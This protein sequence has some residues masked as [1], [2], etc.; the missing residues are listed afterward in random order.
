MNYAYMGRLNNYWWVRIQNI[1][2]TLLFEVWL[3]MFLGVWDVHIMFSWKSLCCLRFGWWCS[4]EFGVFIL[5]FH[6][7]HFVVWGSIDDVLGSLGCLY[8]VFMEVTLLFEVR[9]MMFL[10]EFGMFLLV[11][12][13]P[14]C[15]CKRINVGCCD[16]VVLGRMGCCKN[17]FTFV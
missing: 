1:Y 9:L 16:F 15:V 6:G 12:M 7:S 8:Y 3:M 14:I 2:Y 4:W 13:F 11:S 10:C 17:D 5:C